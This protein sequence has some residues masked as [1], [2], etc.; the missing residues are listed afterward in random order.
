MPFKFIREYLKIETAS[1]ALLFIAALLAFV[2]SNSPWRHH[3]ETLIN[4]PLG[5]HVGGVQFVLP[6]VEWINQGLMTLFFLLVGLEI[7]REIFLGELNSPK[8]I[9][10]PAFAALGGMLLPAI[11]YLIFNWQNGV[12]WRGWAIPTATDIAFSLAILGLLHGRI[13][14]SLKIFLTALAILDDIGAIIIIAIFYTA[15]ISWIFLSFALICLLVLFLLNHFKIKKLVPYLFVGLILWV[16]V[17]Q[18]G[19]HAVL[20]GVVLAFAIPLD[21]EV[22]FDFSPLKALE[23]KLHPWVA[24]LILPLFGFANAGVS[25][26]GTSWNYWLNPVTIGVMLGLLLGKQLGVFGAIWLA[27]KMKL[28]RLPDKAHWLDMYGI[29]L[30]CGVGFTM[31]LFIGTLAFAD[32]SNKY[33]PMVRMG[34]FIGSLLSGLLGYCLLRFRSHVR[35]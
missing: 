27:V 20:V 15:K 3:Y 2:I 14:L 17:L 33:L 8:K 24:F 16:L 9:A 12:T 10:L 11:I 26:I 21:G 6:L 23:Q 35:K 29:A 25:L 22:S 32:G 1:G 7:K 4:M 30:L 31:S 13:A 28:A 34:V 18:S 19:I 5:V